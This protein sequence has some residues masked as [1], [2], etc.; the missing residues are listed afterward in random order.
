MAKATITKTRP[1]AP[2]AADGDGSFL[3][4]PAE[5]EYA[6][7]LAA[8]AASDRDERPDGWNLSP[9]AVRTYILGGKAGATEIRPKYLGSERVV[10]I[11]IATLA[12]DRALLLI[13]EPGTAKSWLSE[14]L[15]AAISG[16]SLRIVQGTAGT[17]EEQIRYSWNYALLLAEGPSP[18]ALVPSPVYR[19]M[20]EGKLV[21]FEEITRCPS[22][23]QDALITLLS[24]KVM[25]VPELGFHLAAK[26]GF[27]LIGTANTRD[28]GVN[29]MSAALKRRFNMVVLP[30]PQDVDTEVQIVTKRVAEIGAGLKLPAPPPA[31]EAVRKIVQI[32]QELRGGQTLDGKQKVKP[33]TGVLSTAEAISLLGNS[34][35]LAGHFG[36][37]KV[38]DRD[39]AAGL[40][41]AVIK[42]DSRDAA[43]WIEYLENVMKKRGAEWRDLYNACKELT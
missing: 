29:D 16:N 35:A 12:T 13:G 27:N 4:S 18:R 3:R 43:I 36:S 41:A 20:Q 2:S 26:R 31:E 1:S 37:G 34:M 42:E 21:R 15:S 17:T 19:A 11:A 30:I 24:E 38:T 40:H 6:A 25:A 7:E 9:K 32:F 33:P 23:V 22:E 5:V 10:E 8:L 28:R 14:H 39:M